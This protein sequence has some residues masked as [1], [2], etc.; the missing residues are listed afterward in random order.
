VG[1]AKSAN[2]SFSG[3]AT[4]INLTT[5]GTFTAGSS[6]VG[7]SV[8][9]ISSVNAGQIK[10]P[11]SQNSSSNVN[12]LDD[13]EEGTW[14]PALTFGS[15]SASLTIGSAT[16]TKV[17]RMVKVACQIEMPSVASPSG[18]LTISGLPFTVSG[19]YQAASIEP[20]N[21]KSAAN[22]IVGDFADASTAIRLFNFAAGVRGVVGSL[23]QSSTAFMINGSYNTT[24]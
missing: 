18:D 24:T 14:I 12:T 11:A 23:V 9:D 21:M 17:G 4:F 10:F 6:I 2:P 1:F 19:G 22:C 5:L 20:F 15:G 8:I 16:Y 13:Y 7:Q 3:N